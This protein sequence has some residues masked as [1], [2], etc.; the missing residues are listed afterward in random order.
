MDNQN[1]RN[2]KKGNC[3]RKLILQYIT[4][5]IEKHSYPPTVRE[6]ADGV[7]LKSA[8][9]VQ[10]HLA[11]MFNDGILETDAG[12]GSPRAIRVPGYRLVKESKE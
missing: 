8:S 9:T 5:Y 12:Y 10:S 1:K 6:I 4:T 7:A 3:M 11:R 2:T